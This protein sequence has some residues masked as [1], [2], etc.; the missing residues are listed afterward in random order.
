M[1]IDTPLL[2]SYQSYKAQP[3][4]TNPFENIISNHRV[5]TN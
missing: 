4:V 1:I 3:L 5:T 2:S